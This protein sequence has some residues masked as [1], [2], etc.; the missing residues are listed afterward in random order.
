MLQKYSSLFLTL[1]VYLI[2]RI[3]SQ[4][5]TATGTSV[6]PTCT[7]NT[8]NYAK[9]G[10]D[11]STDNSACGTEDIQSPISIDDYLGMCDSTQTFYAKYKTLSSTYETVYLKTDPQNRTMYIEYPYINYYLTDLNGY[12]MH[13]E[14]EYIYFRN[15]SEHKLN[16]IVYDV[17]MQVQEICVNF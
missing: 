6:D 5:I 4:C 12:F 11:W 1:Y 17:E 2:N 15:P 7:T 16:D 10:D 9:A 8:Y 13:Y 14:S 3:S